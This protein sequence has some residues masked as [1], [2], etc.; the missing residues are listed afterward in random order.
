M[1]RTIKLMN[2]QYHSSLHIFDNSD[3][4]AKEVSLN[5]KNKE[6]ELAEKIG[7]RLVV[8]VLDSYASGSGIA[9]T[10]FVSQIPASVRH[11]MTTFFYNIEEEYVSNNDLSKESVATLYI[12]NN[13]LSSELNDELK[14]LGLPY[15]SNNKIIGQREYK[16]SIGII[17]AIPEEKTW[18]SNTLQNRWDNDKVRL[19]KTLINGL[20]NKGLEAAGKWYVDQL[21]SVKNLASG[22]ASLG[23]G[24]DLNDALVYAKD[25]AL[26]NPKSSFSSA[27]LL[28]SWILVGL[29]SLQESNFDR[30]DSLGYVVVVNERGTPLEIWTLNGNNKNYFLNE[31]T[32]VI[33][34]VE[35][36]SKVSSDVVKKVNEVQK[37][38]SNVVNEPNNIIE[39]ESSNFVS[40]FFKSILGWFG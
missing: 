30:I 18:S 12:G 8:L 10:A 39:E 2:R 22:L 20:D 3:N 35:D 7:D 33:E 16:G 29:S 23:D 31:Y 37:V 1:D 11:D 19:Y 34:Q 28:Q 14:T 38:T 25:K 26:E 6:A 40:R 15:I 4:K 21:D 5:I 27:V 9:Y 36:V 24:A 32:Q 13:K 17:A